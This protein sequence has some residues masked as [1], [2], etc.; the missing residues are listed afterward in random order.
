MGVIKRQS[1]QQGLVAYFGVFIGAVSTLFIYPMLGK[2]KFGDI[3]FVISLSALLGPLLGLGIPS[4]AVNFFPYFKENRATRGRFFYMLLLTT[5]L[6]VCFFLS[7]MYFNRSLITYFFTDNAYL[8]NNYL[9]YIFA[10]TFCISLIALFTAYIA[11]FNKVVIPTII[12]SLSLKI[13]QPTLVLL[14]LGGWIAFHQILVGLVG[15]HIAIVAATLYYLHHLGRLEINFQKLHVEKPLK[16]KIIDY[17]L[18]SI[19]I[20][21]SVSLALQIDRILIA[22]IIGSGSLAVFTIPVF[23]T[24]AI[25][26]IRK[27]ISSIS[28][29]IISDSLKSNNLANVEMIYKKSALLQ[30][31]MGM[32]LLTCAWICADDLYHLMPKGEEFASGKILILILG[33]SRLIDMITGMNSEIIALSEYYRTNFYMLLALAIVN[34]ICCNYFIRWYG[35]NG[36]AMA[37]FIS[38]LLFNIAKLAFIERKFHMH[39]FSSPMIG[40]VAI[41]VVTLSMALLIPTFRFPFLGDKMSSIFTISVKGLVITACY[42]LL[43]WRFRVVDDITQIIDKQ[44]VKVL[45][46]FNR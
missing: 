16:R 34:I 1:L 39:P 3:Q 37:T 6:S 40:S 7:V 45:R 4:A 44:W 41:G 28:T 36:A 31:V 11:N 25:D 13:L 10:L 46:I 14:F 8:F 9:P 18:F 5:L 15:V 38:M 33:M 42:F 23:I 22:L 12:N 19:L 27:A 35:I 21:L 29:P 26:V 43:L 20:G 2:E 30:F 24:E 17:S 32:F